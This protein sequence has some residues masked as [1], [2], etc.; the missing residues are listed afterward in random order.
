M[1]SDGQVIA[2]SLS[3]IQ[4]LVASFKHWLG[5]KQYVFCILVLKANNGYDYIQDSCFLGQ[6]IKEKMFLFMIFV[7]GNGSGNLM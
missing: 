6:T 5:N 7:H 1:L 3:N 4:I 2:L